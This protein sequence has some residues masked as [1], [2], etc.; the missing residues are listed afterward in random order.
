MKRAAYTRLLTPAERAAGMR[1]GAAL[2]IKKADSKLAAS[3]ILEAPANIMK[4][5]AATSIIAGVPIGIAAH[6]IHRHIKKD[7][8]REMDLKSRIGYFRD[9]TSGMERG[10]ADRAPL[11]KVEKEDE[12]TTL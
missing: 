2:S 9:A 6:M 7:R 12:E 10:L 5:V 3:S 8:T 1:A 4:A 11:Q